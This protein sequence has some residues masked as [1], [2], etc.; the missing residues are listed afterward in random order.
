MQLLNAEL[1]K[2]IVGGRLDGNPFVQGILIQCL[3]RL[4][5]AE[6][7]IETCRGRA[8]DSTFTKSS[9]VENA[10]LQ[11]A[12]AG[13]NRQLAAE[14]GQKMAPTKIKLE[15]LERLSLPNPAMSL[16]SSN[17]DQLRQNLQLVD[18]RHGR[19]ATMSPKRLMLGFD[20]TYLLRGVSQFKMNDVVGLVGG[21]WSPSKED[22][23]FVPIDAVRRDMEK[24]PVMY[25]FLT[26]CPISK[27]RRALSVASMPMNLK[28]P[29][30]GSET[31]T[32]A[33]NWD[34]WLH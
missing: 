13:C 21:P 23:S 29:R 25:E 2:Q 10:A 12:I 24:A 8:A 22:L 33:A 14:L 1:A 34:A 31:Q 11:L 9:L 18:Q 15:E 4:E 19:S 20:A 17:V 28:A 30:N 27:H 5:K 16:L 32:H 26:W 6:R 7:G 3:T